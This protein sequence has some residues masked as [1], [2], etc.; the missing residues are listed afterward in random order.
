M[1]ILEIDPAYLVSLQAREEDATSA[2]QVQRM[3]K[4]SD[5]DEIGSSGQI[6]DLY[7]GGCGECIREHRYSMSKQ[8][9]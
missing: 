7:E 4:Q 1:V 3:S 9:D 6:M 8:S 5:C 2:S